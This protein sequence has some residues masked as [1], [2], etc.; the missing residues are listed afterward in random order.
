MEFVFLRKNK[1][2]C[3]SLEI[4]LGCI[5]D[6]FD[7]PAVDIRKVRKYASFGTMSQSTGKAVGML[8]DSYQEAEQHSLQLFSNGKKVQNRYE[9]SEVERL[10]VTL[11]CHTGLVDISNFNQSGKWNCNLWKHCSY[12]NGGLISLRPIPVLADSLLAKYLENNNPAK[13]P[14]RL[15]IADTMCH[16]PEKKR[17]LSDLGKTVGY[18]KI[19]LSEEEKNHMDRL[20]A[21]DPVTYFEY[22]STD[23]VVTLL[24][25]AGLYGYNHRTPVTIT[26]ISAKVIREKYLCCETNEKISLL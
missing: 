7:F 18:E 26:S 2:Y 11:L 13:Y 22:A 20:L 8:F 17:K 16:A 15:Y 25:A 3:P 4:F 5:L 6:K 12:V 9:W 10:P 19:V 14:V 21:S 24:Y 1:K 23:S